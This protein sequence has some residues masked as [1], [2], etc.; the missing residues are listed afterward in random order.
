M[1]SSTLPLLSS[2]SDSNSQSE[3]DKKS[4]RKLRRKNLPLSL[5]V[6]GHQKLASSAGSSTISLSKPR[7]STSHSA[8][9]SSGGWFSVPGRRKSVDSRRE[10]P[11]KG[12]RSVPAG[13]DGTF[14]SPA[15]GRPSTLLDSNMTIEGRGVLKTRPYSAAEPLNTGDGMAPPPIPKRPTDLAPEI[16][17]KKMVPA[18]INSDFLLPP[19]PPYAKPRRPERSSGSP[20]LPPLAFNRAGDGLPQNSITTQTVTPKDPDPDLR[21]PLSPKHP[22]RKMR[23]RSKSKS[24]PQLDSLSIPVQPPHE[25]PAACDQGSDGFVRKTE[26]R[27]HAVTA[28]EPIVLPARSS[29][30][31]STESSLLHQDP[32]SPKTRPELKK[33]QGRASFLGGWKLAKINSSRSG[34]DKDSEVSHADEAPIGVGLGGG[35]IYNRRG[36]FSSPRPP[37]ADRAQHKAYAEEYKEFRE[38]KGLN[39]SGLPKDSAKS[40]SQQTVPGREV[41][42]GLKSRPLTSPE[43][44]GK[45]RGDTIKNFKEIMRNGFHHKRTGSLQPVGVETVARGVPDGDLVGLDVA[46]RQMGLLEERL[47]AGH[48]ISPPN[49]RDG[50]NIKVHINGQDQKQNDDIAVAPLTIVKSNGIKNEHN[51]FDSE[52]DPNPNKRLSLQSNPLGGSSHMGHRKTKSVSPLRNEVDSS[53]FPTMI[54]VQ[55]QNQ[56]LKGKDQGGIIT[57]SNQFRNF[58]NI[59]S[60][61]PLQPQISPSTP[62]R[63]RAFSSSGV[64]V[65]ISTS[66]GRPPTPPKPIA[67]LFVICCRCKVRF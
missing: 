43:Q 4:P 30:Q 9:H 40:P 62:M 11:T 18:R 27:F 31:S 5:A 65:P 44:S 56:N 1:P 63:N 25:A 41:A 58:A 42:E 2:K 20:A 6:I 59:Q 32:Q 54:P 7:P 22:G 14:M 47:K 29:S 15:N 35:W 39:S 24:P 34:N 26:F 52:T 36:S 38:S 61:L 66:I 16:S 45:S 64:N 46:V 28:E 57:A 8:E 13:S 55:N 3:T 53:T 67:K 10:W 21:P 50:E 19:S 23:S 33:K 51:P 37:T 60:P 48:P 12:F 17:K 49:S